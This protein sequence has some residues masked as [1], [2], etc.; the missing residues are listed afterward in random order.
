MELTP[1]KKRRKK[2]MKKN[3]EISQLRRQGV[4]L[5]KKTKKKNKKIR[6]GAIISTPGYHHLIYLCFLLFDY[7][8]IVNWF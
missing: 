5:G 4:N 8:S 6:Q 2:E 7:L 3:K 1:G